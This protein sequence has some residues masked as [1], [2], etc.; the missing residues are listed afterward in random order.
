VRR[1]VRKEREREGKGWSDGII[2]DCK[3]AILIALS[4]LFERSIDLRDGG[5]AEAR[6]I[7]SLSLHS[8]PYLVVWLCT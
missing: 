4:I 1:N 6:S 7:F 3:A 8:R 5:C 2:S